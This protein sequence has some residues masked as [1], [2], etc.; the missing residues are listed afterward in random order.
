MQITYRDIV[1]D[2]KKGTAVKEILKSEIEKSEEKVIACKFNNEIKSL[3][4]E[5][6]KDGNLELID[7]TSKDGMRIYKRGLIYIICKAFKELYD[8]IKITIDYQLFHSMY[9]TTDTFFFPA[10]FLTRGSSGRNSARGR[11]VLCVTQKLSIR[12]TAI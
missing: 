2:V 4:F 3:N 12:L 5:I 1:I 10:L 8:D 7:L 6:N 9:Y 11:T